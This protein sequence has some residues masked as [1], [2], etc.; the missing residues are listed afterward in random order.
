M[1]IKIELDKFINSSTLAEMF[2]HWGNYKQAEFFNSIGKCFKN[3]N[4][5]TEIRCSHIINN[6]DGNG[7]DILYN[8]ATS[9]KAKGY[10]VQSTKKRQKY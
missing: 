1:E 3:A 5:H 2:I 9:L 8:L 6:I 4:F 7:R 10:Q